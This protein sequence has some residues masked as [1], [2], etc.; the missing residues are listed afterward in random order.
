M[1]VSHVADG[2]PS[3]ALH[4]SLEL[5]SSPDAAFHF[6]CEVEKWPL[7]LSFLRSARRVDP[8]P[9]PFGEGSEIALRGTIPGDVEEYYEVERYIAGH[10]V[11]LVGLYSTRRRIDFR[12]ERKS[13]SARLVVRV[14]YPAYGGALGAFIDRLTARRRLA[15]ALDAS[16]AQLKGLVDFKSATHD[17]A[18][19]DF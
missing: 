4:G 8:D 17:R 10:I 11:S 13:Q 12:I 2:P 16:L 19:V 3:H 18:L 15:S 7:W 6:I 1:V 9:G 14:D 5:G